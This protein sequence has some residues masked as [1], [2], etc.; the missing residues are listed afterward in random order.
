MNAPW[1]REYALSLA[2]AVSG[3]GGENNRILQYL[4]NNSRSLGFFCR[5]NVWI[6]GG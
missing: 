5:L 6:R 1:E 4:P 2:F 3:V